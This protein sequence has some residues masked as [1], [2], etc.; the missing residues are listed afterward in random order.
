M[1]HLLGLRLNAK[2]T[3]VTLA[4]FLP[5][6]IYVFAAARVIYRSSR[7][8]G[9]NNVR[10]AVESSAGSMDSEM[11]MIYRHAVLL[12]RNT[13]MRRLLQEDLPEISSTELMTTAK[14]EALSSVVMVLEDSDYIDRIEVFVNR[15]R[16]FLADGGS[17]RP[18][19][20]IEDRQWLKE[21]LSGNAKNRWCV[22]SAEENGLSGL[23]YVTRVVSPLNYREDTAVLRITY[24]GERLRQLLGYLLLYPDSAALLLSGNGE[25]VAA[26][27]DSDLSRELASET[28]LF[29]ALLSGR[30]GGS[31]PEPALTGEEIVTVQGRR[32]RIFAKT[33]G[34]AD[35]TVI[36]AVPETSFGTLRNAQD[37][38]GLLAGFI[39]CGGW[40][41]LVMFLYSSM[42]VRKILAMTDFV[43]TIHGSGDVKLM[44]PFKARDELKE[45]SDSYNAMAGELKQNLEREYMLGMA[46]RNS[47]L[48]ALQAQINP[49]F[50]YNT[51]ELV[52]YYAFEQQPEIVEEIVKDL[53]DFYRL[54]LNNGSDLYSL[55]K[56]IKLIT[57]WFDIQRIRWQSNFDLKID[58]PEELGQCQIPPFTLQPLVENAVMHGI[59][60]TKEHGGSVGISAR[61][62]GDNIEI[63]VTDDGVGMS[64]ELVEELNREMDVVSEDT[65]SGSH[66]GIQNSNQRL[67]IIF[68]KEYGMSVKSAEDR[69]TTVTVTIPAS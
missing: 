47:D 25:V 12:L 57:S 64:P 62:S 41:L 55:W 29:P 61:R 39:L 16:E 10:T 69:G 49:H 63:L 19:S 15:E 42:L 40:M 33:L 8:T 66:Y 20:E 67:K 1:E 2:Q 17:F 56:E 50:L 31:A 53:A 38:A 34:N 60:G 48:K 3:L 59:R 4:C 14:K 58:V 6:C 28:G 54:G 65:V 23:F 35:F 52:D 18:L 45:L 24:A 32:C 30:A 9:M 26:A 7:E 11:A 44:K 68:G 37:F 36:C 5:L 43:R 22:D 51:L 46:K 27:G 13:E 21:F